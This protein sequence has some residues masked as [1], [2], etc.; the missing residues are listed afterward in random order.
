MAIVSQEPI[1]FACSIR[2]NINYSVEHEM[3]MAEIEKVAKMANIHDF[4][5]SLPTVSILSNLLHML[6]YRTQEFFKGDIFQFD[7]PRSTPGYRFVWR[8][9]SLWTTYCAFYKDILHFLNP[10]TAPPQKK[11]K[12]NKQNGRFLLGT[13]GYGLCNLLQAIMPY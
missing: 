13:P 1:L 5:S 11:K 4:V 6:Q 12:K 2:E 3:D 8:H 7:A 10:N 9:K